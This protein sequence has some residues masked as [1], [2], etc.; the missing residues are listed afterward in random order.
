MSNCDVIF[1][2]IKFLG[3]TVLSF[4][5]N[6]GL[7]SSESTLKVDLIEDCDDGDVFAPKNGSISVGAPVY[8]TAGEFNF[9]GVLAGW[10]ASQG[11]SG[12]TFSADVSD[13][14][15]LLAN[16]V[17][18]IDS[19]LGP[20]ARALNYFN[21]YNY[22]EGQVLEGNCNVFGLSNSNERGM[23][24]SNII[25]ALQQM[26]P[27]IY[28]PTG[29]AFTLNFASFPQGVPEYY[30]VPGP[31]IN[32]LQLLEDVCDVLGYEFYVELLPGAIINIGL[33][34][35]KMPP[36]SFGGIVSS[37]DGTATD[38]SY[39]QELRNEITKTVLFGEKQHYLSRVTKFS[40]FFGEDFINNE[41]V[42]VVPVSHDGC[43]F[44]IDKKIDSL[45]TILNNPIGNNN[46]TYLI[47]EL[48][49]RCAMS[50]MEMWMLRTFDKE[51]DN[52]NMN[53]TL[54]KLIQDTFPDIKTNVKD[55]IENAT[56]GISPS[57]H[58]LNPTKAKRFANDPD[59][60]LFI[61]LE[62]IFNWLKNLGNTYYGKQ[63]IAPLNQKICYYQLENNPIAE[64]FFSDIPTNDGGWVEDGIPVL[65]LTD[66]EL[67][68]F[69]EDDNRIGAFAMF[70]DT[71]YFDT[72]ESDVNG[73]YN[74]PEGS[75]YT[76]DITPPETPIV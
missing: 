7:G 66:P 18:I 76:G 28:S 63:Y 50:S 64:K 46:D 37:F 32:I 38:L 27:T 65:G 5:S 17:V 30:R 54:N 60:F 70:N 75:S 62:I 26:N 58:A 57:D 22:I 71:G 20:P 59:K 68:L 41:F 3:A 6:L 19:Y 39:G 9:G 52:P 10:S 12:Q 69:R 48:D 33:I 13:P 35:L 72:N 44:W 45:N 2:P 31:S 25:T 36:A 34:D 51:F 40:N 53:G 15:Q 73:S 16:S 4:T 61:D 23:P 8:F 29:Y 14:R 56:L 47:H 74:P 43:G 42:P 21:V 11:G 49:I 55:A 24:Y 67:G 1:A